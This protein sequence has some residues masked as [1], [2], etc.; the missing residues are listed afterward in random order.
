[1]HITELRIRHFRNFLK[2]RLCFRPGVNTLIGENG[3]G[4][5]NAL[6]A[7]RLL[8]DETLSRDAIHLRETDFCRELGRLRG[9]WIVVSADFADLDP[10]DGCQLLRHNAAHMDA[11][12]TGTYTFFFRPK[13]EVRKKLHELSELGDSVEKYLEDITIDDYEPLL[14]GRA[15]ANFLDDEVYYR[16]VGNAETGAFPNPEDDDQ[17]TIGVRIAPIHQ[18]V[19]CTF[20]RAL[21]DVITELR[22]NRGNP[23]LGLLRGM[24]ATIELSDARRIV[25]KVESLNQ[26]I[27]TLE[28]IEKLAIGIE[29]VL[30]KAV[31]HTYGPSVSIESALPNS[32]DKLLQRLT[33]LVGD[34]GTSPHRGELREQS[35]GGA[36]LIYLAL[37]LLEYELKL[38]SER[39]A[40]FLLVEEPEAHIH[41][42]VQM[43]LF[44]NLPSDRTQVIVST[45][46]THISS[47]SRIAT[48]NVLVKD[49]DHAEVHQPAR[50]LSVKQV[51]RAERYLDAI[52]STLL[53]A[54]GV[55][56]V[57]GETEQ[58]MIPAMLRAVFGLSPD[59]LGFSV[60]PMN[61]SFFE[62]VAVI[63]SPERLHRPCAIATDLD[64]SLIGLPSD[65]QDD[66]REEAK[67]RAAEKSGSAREQRLTALCNGNPWIDV[68][69][70][71]HTFEVDFIGANN[72]R[73]VV[74]T[75]NE[76]YKTPVRSS[77]SRGKLESD[78][79][80]V[81]GREVLRLATNV[82]KGWFALLASEQLKADTYIPEYLLRAIAFACHLSVGDR[83]LKQILEFRIAA[84]GD[85]GGP[86]E[87][88]PSLLEW[89]NMSPTD[90]LVAFRTA[91]PE[92]ELSYFCEYLENCRA[93]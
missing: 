19:A 67:A 6:Y 88:L 24:E 31:G 60:V 86:P 39:V 45:H 50:G 11:S 51:K 74:G 87:S 52:R 27:S 76:I 46:S 7:L 33:L 22:G 71:E 44:S 21:R 54:K 17:D 66:T 36:N 26:D 49:G 73:E 38:S 28:E 30:R 42:H 63:F 15:R 2:A 9:H 91:L 8:L 37:K 64:R 5:T 62:H 41:T 55:L 34:S 29:S 53:F 20:V 68:F 48:V 93:E 82:G 32:I 10:S 89:K 84:A 57:E 56:L 70:A 1:M 69:F 16:C 23:L 80:V 78:D 77:T 13:P 61:S 12:N 79:L 3:S 58:I 83:E 65:P 90:A 81:A 14:T 43:A 4:K 85:D 40:H 72:A 35:L 18:E 47:A 25:D 75:L 59:E 92:D